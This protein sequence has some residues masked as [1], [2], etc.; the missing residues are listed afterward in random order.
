MQVGAFLVVRRK[1]DPIPRFARD[2]NAI[3]RASSR[4]V[5]LADR[6]GRPSI[7]RQEEDKLILGEAL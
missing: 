6:L 1:A 2:N 7:Q 5:R 3:F 4:G